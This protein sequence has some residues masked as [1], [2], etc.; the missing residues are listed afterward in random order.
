MKL[1][2]TRSKSMDGPVQDL[3][4]IIAEPVS[5]RFKGKIHTMKPFSLAEFLKFTNAQSALMSLLKD[6]GAIITTKD[7]ADRYHKVI[8]SVCPSIT[9]DDILSMEQVQVAALYQLIIDMVTGQVDR[10]D[11]E[12]K[13][14]RQK[15]QIYDSVQPSSLQSAQGNSVGRLMKP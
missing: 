14:K 3:D 9:V 4:A 15:L 2:P 6:E 8:S 11:G 5:F 12:V 1:W 13:K 10:G 7:L